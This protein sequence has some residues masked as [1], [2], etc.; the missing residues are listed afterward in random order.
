MAGQSSSIAAERR[1]DTNDSAGG[2][3]PLRLNIYKRGQGNAIRLFV[4]V[5]MA[6]IVFSGSR[7]IYLMPPTGSAWYHPVEPT[8]GAV[9]GLGLVAGAVLLLYRAI[10][11]GRE[12]REFLRLGAMTG[13]AALAGVL[14][15]IVVTRAFGSVEVLRRPMTGP[16]P[17]TWGLVISALVF[18]YGIWVVY[19][20]LINH[21]QR[22]D[23]LIETETELRKVA[24]PTRREYI[25]SSIVVIVMVALV[26]L[27]LT[28]VD[29]LL[30][31][32]MTWLRIG[33]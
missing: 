1:D 13:G 23:F 19:R 11:R 32:L 20:V 17:V 7:W 27:Y 18:L 21:P 15:W 12:D 33:Y 5:V 8:P 4:F 26:S 30:N 16:L 3:L 28:A 14:A 6:L 31:R 10:V 9:I 2:R 25:G 29:M 24:W 22:T